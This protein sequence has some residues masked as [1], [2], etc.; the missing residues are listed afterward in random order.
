MAIHLTINNGWS[1]IAVSSKDVDPNIESNGK[2]LSL[3]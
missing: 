1:N 3:I 2:I